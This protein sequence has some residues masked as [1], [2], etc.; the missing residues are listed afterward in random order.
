M[1]ICISQRPIDK[2]ASKNYVDSYILIRMY[3]YVYLCMCM[4]MH[5][6]VC[7]Y[8]YVYT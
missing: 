8:M 4:H 7:V 3:V 1:Q 6:C 5:M 2:Q